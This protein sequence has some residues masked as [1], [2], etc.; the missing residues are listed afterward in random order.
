MSSWLET[1]AYIMIII[2]CFTII[3]TLVFYM[4]C[5]LLKRKRERKLERISE[6]ESSRKKSISNI[7][8]DIKEED[9]DELEQEHSN[10]KFS[11]KKSSNNNKGFMDKRSKSYSKKDSLVRD[12]NAQS[13]TEFSSNSSFNLTPDQLES[14][15][16]N[17]LRSKS[18]FETGENKENHE[19]SD[20]SIWQYLFRLGNS[21]AQRSVSNKDSSATDD[22][23]DIESQNS[24]DSLNEQ[25]V[26]LS[27]KTRS[28]HKSL[29]KSG[30][31]N[32]IKSNIKTNKLTT[33]AK[34]RSDR[35]SSL[36]VSAHTVKFK[37][38]EE[39]DSSDSSS[40]KQ[41]PVSKLPA[42][43]LKLCQLNN[44]NSSSNNLSNKSRTSSIVSSRKN[45]SNSSCY[46]SSVVDLYR[47]KRLSIASSL[48]SQ[49]H[50][51][52]SLNSSQLL[53]DGDSRKFSIN[54]SMADPNIKMI[55]LEQQS[56]QS[57]QHLPSKVLLAKSSIS[58]SSGYSSNL[59]PSLMSLVTNK[60]R[61]CSILTN[62]TDTSE[63][64]WVPPEIARKTLIEKQ[65]NSIASCTYN[66]NNNQNTSCIISVSAQDSE[67]NGDAKIDLM[68]EI[69]N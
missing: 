60:S 20:Q 58:S 37:E 55:A 42:T 10:N 69:G 61:R 15:K 25:S 49:T 44:S 45:S 3:C 35:I 21:F 12:L 47:Q 62:N 50:N 32:E 36:P 14:N 53:R 31:K 59:S 40:H 54:Y 57:F 46:E 33:N 13:F 24:N 22:N 1:W 30:I 34:S 39:H 11:N 52:D 48:I 28:I 51:S 64:F 18:M 16:S 56:N 43:R 8:N 17:K 67:E 66:P 26:D 27:T 23:L 19:S 68:S 2:V 41:E 65:R 38:S 63:K 6:T 5:F 7:L 4:I 9:E 29:L